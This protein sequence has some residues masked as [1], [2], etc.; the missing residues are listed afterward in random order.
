[1]IDVERVYGGA[2]WFDVACP[3]HA[4]IA[5]SISQ[6]TPI[7]GAFETMGVKTHAQKS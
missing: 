7:S 1:L 4:G 3:D 2:A 6:T 5:N